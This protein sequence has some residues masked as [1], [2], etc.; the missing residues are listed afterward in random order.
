MNLI[1]NL[2]ERRPKTENAFQRRLDDVFA[3]ALVVGTGVGGRV[4]GLGRFRVWG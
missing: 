4:E 2:K 1:Y 3:S